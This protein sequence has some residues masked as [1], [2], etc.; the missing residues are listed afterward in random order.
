MTDRDQHPESVIRLVEDSRRH[1]DILATH[2]T[3]PAF[4]DADLPSALTRMV[5]RARQARIRLLVGAL[6][7]G[8]AD[9]HPLILLSRRL[10]SAIAVR[11]LATHPEWSGETVILGD[12]HLGL[13]SGSDDKQLNQLG[14]AARARQWQERFDRLWLAARES[15]ELRQFH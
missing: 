6:E 15:P 14:S 7:P 10:P 12:G 13:I 2:L 9:H 3:T 4:A 11:E 1:V 8:R 5:R